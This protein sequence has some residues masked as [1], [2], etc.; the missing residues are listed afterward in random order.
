M[1]D[2][3]LVLVIDPEI[4][5]VDQKKLITKIKK[6][7]EELKGKVE[8]TEEWGKKKFAYPMKKKSLGYYFLWMVK[9]PPEGP[10]EM[11][12]QLKLEEKLIRYLL[13]KKE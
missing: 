10:S 9:L 1:R 13:V 6:I 2:Y 3:E 5:G 4:S 8:K 11:E 12:K 7:I